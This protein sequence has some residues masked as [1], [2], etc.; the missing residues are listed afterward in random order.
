MKKRMRWAL[1]LWIAVCLLISSC[2]AA[3]TE[4]DPLQNPPYAN[5]YEEMYYDMMGMGYMAERVLRLGHAC[6]SVYA[7]TSVFTV[8]WYYLQRTGHAM[9]DT[10]FAERSYRELKELD[11]TEL[12]LIICHDGSSE[13]DRQDICFQH[14]VKN[15]DDST[16]LSE[17]R[18]DVQEDTLTYRTT[19]PTQAEPDAFLQGILEAWV[20]YNAPERGLS[21]ATQFSK[22]AGWGTYEFIAEEGESHE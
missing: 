6:E 12:V 11:C 8:R 5:V 19:D 7:S 18:Y 13:R 20:T 14:F 2:A 9:T 16:T 21:Y 22:E 3:P 15:E 10:Y 4:A 17:Y 1:L